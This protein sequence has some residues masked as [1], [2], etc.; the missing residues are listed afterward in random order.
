MRLA[1]LSPL[2]RGEVIMPERA[3]AHLSAKLFLRWRAGRGVL[4]QQALRRC[5]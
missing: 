1:D 4:L 5:G 2:A 3:L